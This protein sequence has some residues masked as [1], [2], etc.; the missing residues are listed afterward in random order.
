MSAIV[1][2]LW[3]FDAWLWKTRPYFQQDVPS[4]L[5]RAATQHKKVIIRYKGKTYRVAPYSYRRLKRGDALYAYD[6]QDRRI[7]SFY[8]GGVEGV[9]VQRKTFRPKWEVELV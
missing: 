4:V 7:K 5:A 9:W 1:K 3:D 8:V 2:S 6:F